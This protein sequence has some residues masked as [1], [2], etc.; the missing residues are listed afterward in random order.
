MKVD[1]IDSGDVL[2][3]L[4]PLWATKRDMGVRIRAKVGAVLKWSIAQGYRRDD[5]MPSVMAALPRNG[6]TVEHLRTLPHAEIGAVLERV[7]AVELWPTIG[8]AVEFVAL[9][10]CRS[11]EVRGATW[12]EIDLGARIWTIPAE[13]MKTGKG[14]RVPLSTRAV[15][16]LESARSFADG[17]GLV[18]PSAR[19]T[20]L[21]DKTLRRALDKA[22]LSETM[23]IHGMRSAFRDWCGDTGK[24]REIAEAALAHAAGS[25]IEAAYAR[26]DLFNRRVSLM[27]SWAAY[28]SGRPAKVVSFRG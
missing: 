15:E 13:R 3:V 19:S 24:P 26:S 14:H 7:R 17:S 1:A 10:A 22:G 18:F 28:L 11:G 20:Q 2:A 16:I 8:L 21:D 25:K 27:E 5:P 9:T 4:S 12:A 6:K 23:T